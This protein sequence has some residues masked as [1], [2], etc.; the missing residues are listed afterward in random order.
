MS[1]T[2]EELEEEL[3]VDNKSTDRNEFLVYYLQNAGKYAPRV[4]FGKYTYI[5]QYGGEGMGDRYYVIFSITNADGVRYF[6]CETYYDSWNGIDSDYS[7]E[8]V[9]ER[10]VEATVFVNYTGEIVDKSF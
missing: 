1:Y 5:N 7:L 8:E 10:K 9:W 3:I 2:I 6:K 4:P